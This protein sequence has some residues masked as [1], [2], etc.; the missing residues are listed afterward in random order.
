MTES[1]REQIFALTEHGTRDL[2]GGEVL[3]AHFVGEQTD[4]V[5]WNHAL[6]RQ[7]MTVRQGHLALSLVSGKKRDDLQEC[8]AALRKHD[9]NLDL[10]Y[11]NFRE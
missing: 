7:P 9:F 11:E 4:F 3:L 5:R 6:V 1:T 8:I 10:Q 2:S